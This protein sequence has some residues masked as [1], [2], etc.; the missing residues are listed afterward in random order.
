[1]FKNSKAFTGNT[2]LKVTV[3]SRRS[4]SVK[5]FNNVTSVKALMKIISA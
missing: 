5:V 4:S 2:K 3:K 1:M